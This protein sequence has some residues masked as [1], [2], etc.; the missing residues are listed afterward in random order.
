MSM[1]LF[2]VTPGPEVTL[3]DGSLTLQ[4]SRLAVGTGMRSPA[5][6]KNSSHYSRPTS[7]ILVIRGLLPSVFP[8]LC[9]RAQLGPCLLKW[10]SEGLSTQSMT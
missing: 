4:A 1:A 6:G 9:S 5:D 10:A 2:A 3:A 8:F 7:L